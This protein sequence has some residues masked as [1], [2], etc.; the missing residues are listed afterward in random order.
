MFRQRGNLLDKV[1][2]L[3]PSFGTVLFFTA[4]LNAT[5][6]FSGN[7]RI[8]FMNLTSG[9]S[10]M[11]RPVSNAHERVHIEFAITLNQIIAL[12]AKHQVLSTYVWITESW[13]DE[14]LRWQPQDFY[15]VDKIMFSASN[16]WL[17]D[18]Y[19]FNVAGSSLEGFVNVSGSN[20]LV[21]SEGHVTWM[22]PLRIKSACPVDATFFP[23]DKQSCDIHFGSWIYD[24][25]QID[26][27]INSSKPDL[28]NYV[29]NNEFDLASTNIVRDIVDSTCCPGDGPHPMVHFNI[30]LKRKTNYYDYIVIAPTINLC[31]L[32][33][34]TFLL[35]CECG[36]K[37]AIG[38]TVFLTLYVLQ[39]LIAENVPDTSSTPLISVFLLLVMSL[40]CI[41]LITATI[42]MNIKRL[43]YQDPPPEVPK[44]L[45]VLCE[46]YLSKIIC[47][48]LADWKRI[49]SSPDE[50]LLEL[51]QTSSRMKLISKIKAMNLKVTNTAHGQYVP[52]KEVPSQPYPTCSHHENRGFDR[53]ETAESS[54]TLLSINS[55]SLE[56]L[57]CTEHQTN[58]SQNLSQTTVSNEYDN[59]NNSFHEEEDDDVYRKFNYTIN[60]NNLETSFVSRRLSRNRPSYRKAIRSGQMHL[61]FGSSNQNE[62]VVDT[63]FMASLSQ[64]YQWYFVADTL[65]T[66]TFLIYLVV[67][68]LGIFTVLV[69]TPLFA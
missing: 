36:W 63:L 60:G 10:A 24:I 34:A 26:I 66:I 64:K 43:S 1:E 19:I 51:E 4:V 11:S 53:S 6:D 3:V 67:M 56:G 9:Y 40:N 47:T 38:L 41:S 17:P 31:I 8:L 14:N 57:K 30:R 29:I 37:I 68:F 55:D 22:V 7:E 13:Y 50:R 42:I 61:E 20:V 62:N 18:I 28:R 52:L 21:T 16:I 48:R 39:L 59:I 46:K 32:T 15:G 5:Q 54:F 12:D 27:S 33:L 44:S 45:L 2:Y 25:S 65:D 23:Y 35:P 49:A 58:L 69:I